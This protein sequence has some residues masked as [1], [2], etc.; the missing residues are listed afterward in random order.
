MREVKA[1]ENINTILNIIIKNILKTI[2]FGY[3]S[4]IITLFLNNR[5]ILIELEGGGVLAGVT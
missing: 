4:R 3:K 1:R 5:N 2:I